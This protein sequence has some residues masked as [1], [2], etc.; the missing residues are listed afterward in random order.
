LFAVD[1][2]PPPNAV[3]VSLSSPLQREDVE[4]GLTIVAEQLAVMRNQ[5]R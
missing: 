1:D 4:R 5:K 2:T 3:R